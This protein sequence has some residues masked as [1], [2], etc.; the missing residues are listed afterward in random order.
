MQNTIKLGFTKS[1]AY[2]LCGVILMTAL[3]TTAIASADEVTPASTEPASELVTT[4]EPAATD[5][6]ASAP[7]EATTDVTPAPT[8]VTKEGTTINVE[9][10][11]VA[12]EFPTGTDKYHGFKVE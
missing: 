4:T 8:T 6:E 3:F 5:A 11:N 12:L 2:G 10:P 7:T 1:K 9:N